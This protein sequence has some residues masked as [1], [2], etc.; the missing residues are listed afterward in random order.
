MTA[1][2]Q[3][4]VDALVSLAPQAIQRQAAR[5]AQDVFTGI[6]RQAFEPETTDLGQTLQTV[7]G[8]CSNWCQAAEGEE[9]QALR[10]ALLI[11]G[12]DQ[13]GLAYTQS[14]NL[15]AMPA[16]SA[17]IG[18]LRSRQDARADARFQFYFSQIEAIEADAVDFR[19]ELRRAIHM[20]LW[21]AMALSEEEADADRMLQSL[22]NLMLALNDRMPTL[23]WRL[24]ADTLAHIQSR[25]LDA[26][27]P[28]PAL[29]HNNTQR[30]FESLRQALP[31]ERY[32]AI[33]AHATQA[34]LAWQQARR[35]AAEGAVK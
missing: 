28:L 15:T 5:M 4:P 27:T 8:R 11:S 10:L 12:L 35:A 7:E 26:D 31:A 14:F 34:I 3:I 21:H 16:L 17:L 23:G 24:L 13:W 20:A 30:L 33:M 29:A 9:A 25:L 22:G 2:A 1:A 19:I 18:A 6:F 32:Q